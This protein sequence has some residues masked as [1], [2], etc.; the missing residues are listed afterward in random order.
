MKKIMLIAL[1][2]LCSV[3][4]LGQTQAY[5]LV[6]T[7]FSWDISGVLRGGNL[8]TNDYGYFGANFGIWSNDYSFS[9]SW[10][11]YV[12]IDNQTGTVARYFD[13]TMDRSYNL[14]GS[15]TYSVYWYL[16]G[17]GYSNYSDGA[18]EWYVDAEMD[19]SGSYGFLWLDQQNYAHSYLETWDGTTYAYD[20]ESVID[21]TDA[22]ARAGLGPRD[23]M[24]NRS[25]M[26]L[27]RSAARL[28]LRSGNTWDYG[29]GY[30]QFSGTFQ[31]VPEP[32]SL[33]LLG[34]GLL[35]FIAYARVR[36]RRKKKE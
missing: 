12:E 5:A 6:P 3:L 28:G 8:S 2:L 29:Y 30:A 14:D 20:Y 34:S 25:K 17:Y 11:D 27:Q 7:N 4:M 22:I 1:L 15:K 33:L 10:G 24:I 35:G 13:W 26:D 16:Y 18:F 31:P 32:S 21:P 36:I 19:R 23:C 9:D